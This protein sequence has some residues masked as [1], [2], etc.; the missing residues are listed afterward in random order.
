[1]TL[2]GGR[3]CAGPPVQVLGDAGRDNALLVTADSGRAVGRLRQAGQHLP[4]PPVAHGPGQ[5]QVRTPSP[6]RTVVPAREQAVAHTS[7]GPT[8]AS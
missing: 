6:A 1:M 3:G 5:P 2:T 8:K 4:A 7:E